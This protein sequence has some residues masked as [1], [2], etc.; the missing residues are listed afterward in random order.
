MPGLPAEEGREV[1]VA[2]LARPQEPDQFVFWL[3]LQVNRPTL[4]AIVLFDVRKHLVETNPTFPVFRT[5]SQFW[6]GSPDGSLFGR[7]LEFGP[8]FA[9][10]RQSFW[11]P[12][13]THPPDRPTAAPILRH[14]FIPALFAGQVS[15]IEFKLGL[16]VKASISTGVLP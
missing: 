7:E 2:I 13:Q 16:L 15:S 5:Q 4:L 6:C 8:G 12:P 9:G 11:G 10:H 3:H 1:S 14:T